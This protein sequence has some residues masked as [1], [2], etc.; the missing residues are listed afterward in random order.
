MSLQQLSQAVQYNCHISD[1]RHGG[2]YGL[3]TYLMK[4][5][6][7]FRWEKGL[8]YAEQLPKEEVGEW[9]AERE[10]LWETLAE[11]EYRPLPINGGE[12]A[13]FEVESINQQLHAEGL[14]YSAGYGIKNKP[15]FFLAQLERYEQPQGMLLLVSGRELARDLSAPAA[16]SLG[17]QIF[18]RRESLRR[19]LWEKL[20]SW[21]WH[22]PDNALGRAFACYDFEQELESSLDA[23]VEREIE[24]VLLH[25]QGECRVGE[26]L[27]ESWGEMLMALSFTPAELMLRAVRDHWSDCSSSLPGL[28]A[29]GQAASIH[30][31]FGN[32]GGMRR[33]LF[34]GALK[35]YE[36]WRSAGGTE[37][38]EVVARMGQA[39]WERIAMESLQLY[40]QQ[41][42]EAASAIQQLI[43]SNHL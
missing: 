30:F 26:A 19:L 34:P 39:H 17:R 1:A 24:M 36:E 4:M 9:L 32:L 13:P 33:E 38:L 42:S 25:E 21:R 28:I 14:V 29:Q 37:P 18:L 31:W 12:Y 20:E 16:M 27:G 15:H 8:G 40:Q 43:G 7:Y 6:E 11:A 41:G 23:M 3:C 22:R 35:A 5:R 10:S 2:D